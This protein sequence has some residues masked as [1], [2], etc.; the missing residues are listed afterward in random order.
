MPGPTALASRP[1]EPLD[2]PPAPPAPPFP[3]PVRSPHPS[4]LPPLELPDERPEPTDADLRDA[5]LPL[6]ESAVGQ[7]LYAPETGIHSFLEP[8]LRT[9]V[10]RALAELES[11]EQA[12]GSAGLLD[13]MLWRLQALCTSRTYDDIVF[14]KTARHR[15]EAALLLGREALDLISYA[16]TDPGCHASPRRVQPLL[17]EILPHLRDRDGALNLSFELADDRRGVVREGHFT[18]LIAIVRGT[19]DEFAQADLDFVQR[20]IEERFGS[21]LHDPSAPL[22]RRLQPMLEDCLLIRSPAAGM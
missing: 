9:T 22:L 13:R 21:R 16:S 2:L 20:R 7:A 18:Y 17:R 8:L 4:G 6:V 15:I 5:L 19:L 1:P 14:A 3:S 11:P 12:F 10:R